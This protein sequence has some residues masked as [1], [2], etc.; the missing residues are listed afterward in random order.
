MPLLLAGC[1]TCSVGLRIVDSPA[2]LG[3]PRVQLVYGLRVDGLVAQYGCTLPLRETLD[4]Y[5]AQ[6]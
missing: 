4:T 5:E 2:A 1:A 6:E 3:G